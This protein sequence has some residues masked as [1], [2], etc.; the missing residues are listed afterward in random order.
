MGEQCQLIETERWVWTCI[1]TSSRS[2]AVTQA[3]AV[4]LLVGRREG[5]DEVRDVP[6]LGWVPRVHA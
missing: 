4:L 3:F 6:G 2:G 5:T 1:L